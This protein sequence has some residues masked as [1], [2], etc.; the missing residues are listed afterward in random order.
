MT[1]EERLKVKVLVIDDEPFM[2]T[3][4]RQV[5]THLGLLPANIYEANG[6]VTGLKEAVRVRPT[7]ILCDIHMPDGHGFEF[8]SKLHKL[9]IPDLAAAPVIM[10]TSDA[11]EAAVKTALGMK[12][13]GY[14]VKPI[15]INSVKVG[16]SRVVE[17]IFDE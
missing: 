7:V 17:G 14:L 12:A 6:A 4:L 8:M 15:S 9:P 16:I 10:L 5:L 13:A 2:R 1:P 11:S 3:T